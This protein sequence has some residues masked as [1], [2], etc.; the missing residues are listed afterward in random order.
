MGGEIIW[1]NPWAFALLAVAGPF[2]L[3]LAARERR[4]SATLRFPLYGLLRSGPRGLARLWW[5]PHLLRQTAVKIG[6]AHV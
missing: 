2:V 5:L 3:W 1:H 6:R 4:R